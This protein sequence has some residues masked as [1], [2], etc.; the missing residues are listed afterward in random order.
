MEAA[1]FT[2]DRDRLDKMPLMEPRKA[3][4]VLG[5]PRKVRQVLSSGRRSLGGRSAVDGS[6]EE[7]RAAALHA[8]VSTRLRATLLRGRTGQASSAVPDP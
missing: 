2:R 6:P 5:H 4:S 1:S 8:K 3:S 7:V